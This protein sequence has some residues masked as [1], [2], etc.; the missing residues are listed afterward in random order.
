MLAGLSEEICWPGFARAQ[1]AFYQRCEIQL[2]D[3]L[4][5]LKGRDS[6]RLTL[7]KFLNLKI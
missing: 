2:I 6:H 4:S 7:C 5:V 3:V 1:L